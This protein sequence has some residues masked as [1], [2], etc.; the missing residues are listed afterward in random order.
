MQWRE[1][2]GR[3]WDEVGKEWLE[4]LADSKYYFHLWG[5]SSDIDKF[6]WW[7]KLDKFCEYI[8]TNYEVVNYFP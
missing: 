5:H 6:M 1:Y 8:K 7:N 3:E 4:K 2:K